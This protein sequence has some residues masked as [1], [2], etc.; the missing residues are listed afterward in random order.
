MYIYIYLC[1]VC[2]CVCGCEN[3]LSRL[4]GNGWV[5]NATYLDSTYTSGGPQ[6]PVYIIHQGGKNTRPPPPFRS[7]F[8]SPATVYDGVVNLADGEFRVGGNWGIA[9][10]L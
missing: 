7:D 5:C 1:C 2:L 6:H 3:I 8:H 4:S 9:D 10:T